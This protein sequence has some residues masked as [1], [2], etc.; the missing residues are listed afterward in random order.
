MLSE[1]HYRKSSSRTLRIS[2]IGIG[3]IGQI[4][5]NDIMRKCAFIDEVCFL[6]NIEIF[7]K[8]KIKIWGNKIS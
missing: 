7:F 2:P 4:I 8:T 1:S 5:W 3:G 6:N